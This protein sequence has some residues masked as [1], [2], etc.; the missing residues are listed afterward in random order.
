MRDIEKAKKLE[1]TITG[2]KEDLYLMQY[3]LSNVIVYQQTAARKLNYSLTVT[4]NEGIY[5]ALGTDNTEFILQIV[6]SI[7][8][9]RKIDDPWGGK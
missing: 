5:E 3:L 9:Q 2:K 1:L 7:T 6:D 4:D 8:G